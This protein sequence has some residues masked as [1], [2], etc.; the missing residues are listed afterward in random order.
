MFGFTLIWGS[1]EII[2]YSA[3]WMYLAYLCAMCRL[4]SVRPSICIWSHENLI[5]GPSRGI[6]ISR[7]KIST[8]IHLG[9]IWMDRGWATL[10]VFFIMRIIYIYLGRTLE[11]FCGR[12]SNG[13][14]I[15]LPLS[16]HFMDFFFSLRRATIAT[17]G[18]KHSVALVF[19]PR[20]LCTV[21]SLHALH[22]ISCAFI[23]HV[24]SLDFALYSFSYVCSR[25]SANARNWWRSL[26]TNITQ[27][28]PILKFSI[29]TQQFSIL[30][31]FL[32]IV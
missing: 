10:M 31:Q 14:L 3:L 28:A 8:L 2:A 20:P 15:L 26:S 13:D 32:P 7:A 21:C 29:F 5:N 18:H 12:F 25:L 23:V 6:S 1:R 16:W 4:T 19:W 9:D 22:R 30:R 24:F 11:S 27:K 17:Y